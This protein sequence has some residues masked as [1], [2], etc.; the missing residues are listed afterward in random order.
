MTVGRPFSMW[1]AVPI[2]KG[3][4]Q[5][6]NPLKIIIQVNKEDKVHTLSLLNT[7]QIFVPSF[8]IQPISLSS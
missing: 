4:E 2:W 5:A 3:G 1:S 6:S 8:F 7:G